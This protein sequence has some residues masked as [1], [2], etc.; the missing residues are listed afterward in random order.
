ML[1]A[2]LALCAGSAAAQSSKMLLVGMSW[3][4]AQGGAVPNNA[5]VTGFTPQAWLYSCR[6]TIEGGVHL[7]KIR[8]GLS[9]CL[10]PVGGREQTVAVYDVLSGPPQKWMPATN[11]EVPARAVDV[12]RTAS[13]QP[14]YV[15]RGVRNNELVPGKTG[16][17]LR[18]CN[19]GV[20]GRE[21]VL[22]IYEVLIQ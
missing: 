6:G 18:G 3:V 4:G 2:A 19:V 8:A 5:V 21:V 10:I 12:G 7:G 9:G 15:C 11:G 14:L 22:A 1:V 13:D 20:G 17:G 16:A